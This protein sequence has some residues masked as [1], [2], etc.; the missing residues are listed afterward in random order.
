VSIEDRTGPESEANRFVVALKQRWWLV[1]TTCLAAA[2]IAFALSAR[3]PAVYTA[4]ALLK[5]SDTDI[6]NQ[7]AGNGGFSNRNTDE[8]GATNVV[9][10]SRRPIAVEASKRLGGALSADDLEKRL[11]ITREEQTTIVRVSADDDKPERAAKIA[12]VY[13][14]TYRD[15]DRAD[16]QRRLK[17]A[18]GVVSRQLRLLSPSQRNGPTGQAL[19]DRQA[20]LT[21]LSQTDT[22]RVDIVQAAT[23]PEDPSSAPPLRNALLA[24]VLGLV[25]GL[26]LVALREQADRRV[27]TETDLERAYGAPVLASIPR[28]RALRAG[29]QFLGDLPAGDAEVFRLLQ[30]QLRYATE[31]GHLESVL[32]TSATNSEGKT[33]TAW[34]LAA[35]AAAT[36]SRVLLLEADMRRPT[37]AER[38]GLEGEE[39]LIDILEGQLELEDAVQEVEVASGRDLHVIV[40]GPSSVNPADLA[41][42]PRVPHLMRAATAAYELVVVDTPPM[43]VVSDAIPFAKLADGVIVVSQNARVTPKQIARLRDQLR[44]LD[45]RLIGVVANGF[46][47]ERDTRYAYY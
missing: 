23:P 1:L 41:Q 18:Q 45:T 14:E 39:G 33:T 7:I 32:V 12:N 4:S 2:L 35:A 38:Y 28:S 30:A 47:A 21:V 5:F 44:A 20:E 13:S 36:G 8:A 17:A 40:A 46:D 15:I 11:T 9:L 34:G 3:N 25:L 42:S 31:P 29:H 24:G 22:G 43:S 26:G 10:V 6:E 19:A 37:L 16:L 27:R